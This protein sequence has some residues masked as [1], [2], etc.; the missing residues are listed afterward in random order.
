MSSPLLLAHRPLSRHHERPRRGLWL[1]PCIL[2]ITV[3]QN[4]FGLYSLFTG[5]GLVLYSYDGPLFVKVLKDALYATLVVLVFWDAGRRGTIPFTPASMCLLLLASTLALISATHLDIMTALAGMRWLLPLVVFMMLR[6]WSKD[7]DFDAGVPWLITGLVLCLALQIVQLFF[8]HPIFGELMPGIA[9]R[10]PGFFVA[11]NSTSFFAAAS[12]ACCMVFQPQ[13]RKL[14]LMLLATAFAIAALAQ[15]GTGIVGVAVLLMRFLLARQRILF[16]AIGALTVTVIFPNLNLL[17]M[18]EDYL[19]LS[20]G[21]RLDAAW[22]IITDAS[23]SFSNFGLYTNTANLLSPDPESQL[24]PDSMIASWIGNFGVFSFVAA[25]LVITFIV[26]NMRDIDWSRAMPCA[27]VLVLFSMT[28]VTFEAFPMNLL[29]TLG[30]WGCR[31]TMHNHITDST[32]TTPI[33][34]R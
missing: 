34:D 20:G 31:R 8:M 17:L 27:L 5:S 10:T 4:V 6:V 29:L 14:H 23:L 24:A 7:I 22:T 16:W 11:P 28:T 9:A 2:L 32:H 18:R 3:L 33:C 26:I 19:A 30:I 1:V 15:S 25:L 21:G 13:R 12:V